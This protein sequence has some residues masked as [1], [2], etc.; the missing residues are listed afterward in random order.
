MTDYRN[1]WMLVA[2]VTLLQL[3]GGVLGVVTPLGLDAFGVGTFGV[4][5]VAGFFSIGFMLGAWFA[6]PAIRAVGNIRVHAAGGALTAVSIQMMFMTQD[7]WSWSIIRLLQGV[8]I[9][10]MFASIDAWLGAAVPAERRGSVSGFYHFMA[11][12]ALIAGP[13]FVAGMS[14]IQPEPYIWG[15]IFFA[16]SLLPLCLTRREQ[17]P[18]PDTEPLSLQQLYAMSPSG[19]FAVLVAGIVNTGLLSLLPIYAM[20][21]LSGLSLSATSLGALAAGAAWTGGL[22]SQWPA[23]KLSDRL[24]RR[25]VIAVMVGLSSLCALL[26]SLNVVSSP[27]LIL[28]IIG[29]W[30]AGSLSFYGIAVAHVIDWS[31]PGKIAQAMTGILFIWASGS[32]LGPLFAGGA[33]LTPLGPRGLF[34]LAAMLGIV[35]TAAMLV[36][37]ASRSEPPDANQEPWTPTTP[38]LIAKG[39]VDPRAD[40]ESQG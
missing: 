11:K 1:V 32:V 30:G 35:L 15:A 8:S 3:G 17:P 9:A 24:D 38:L 14:A 19:I 22:L 36:R 31:P 39:E 20:T 5:V 27:V 12:A 23:G 7:I 26:L 2:A 25:T 28:F 34:A 10:L 18:V 13:F 21:E 6:T 40:G 4:G 16:L 29:V 33:M 37:R